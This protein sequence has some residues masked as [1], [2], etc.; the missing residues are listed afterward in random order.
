[1]PNWCNNN[2]VI[3]HN[4]KDKIKALFDKIQQ[5]TSKNYE[6]NDFGTTWLGNV[7]YGSEIDSDNLEYRGLITSLDFVDL[8]DKGG[9]INMFA[10]TAWCPMIKMWQRVVDKYCSGADITFSAE[11]PGCGVYVT[12]DYDYD[13]MYVIDIYGDIPDGFENGW[14]SM[15]E[16]SEETVI[17]FCQKALKTDET[18]IE[19]LLESVSELDWVS[20]NK[21]EHCEIKDCK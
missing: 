15:W 21:W 9:E 6:D 18:D 11:E 1:M 12:N 14:E 8:K 3:T 13:G 19:K 5:W 7:V 10:D 4:D 16:A 17:D 20:I 2:I